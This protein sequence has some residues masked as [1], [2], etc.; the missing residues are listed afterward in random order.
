MALKTLPSSTKLKAL[1][2]E[3]V[4][5]LSG[6]P[7]ICLIAAGIFN[8]VAGLFAMCCPSL[9]STTLG[10]PEVNLILLRYIGLVAALFGTAYLVSSTDI[11]RY[12]PLI[13]VGLATKVIAPFGYLIATFS[14]E[15]THAMCWAVL[16][17]HVV[18]ILPFSI[19]VFKAINQSWRKDN[20]IGLEIPENTLS[21]Y[22]KVYKASKDKSLL[23]IFLRHFGCAFCQEAL[24]KVS[25][26]YKKLKKQDVTPVLVHMGE[27]EDF[28]QFIE[29]KGL[30]DCLEIEDKNQI[31]YSI[32]SIPRA[33]LR[34]AF[35]KGLIK[36]G[37]KV[38]RETGTGIGKLKGDGFQ[39]GGA[40]LVNNR[41]VTRVRSNQN[42][43]NDFSFSEFASGRDSSPEATTDGKLTLYYE[44]ACPVCKIEID[45]LKTLTSP[46]HVQYVD[47]GEEGLKLPKGKSKQDL[48]AE[49]HAQTESGE[50]VTGMEVFRKVYAHTPYSSIFNL[51]GLPVLKQLFDFSYKIFAKIRPYL[52]G[53]KADCQGSCPT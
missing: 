41:K 18:W 39:L 4:A 12:W 13:A 43:R 8:I 16:L 11:I 6:W 53:R 36:D 51:T 9:L 42:V 22:S 45:L 31:F 5:P 47:I 50:W 30:K 15:S 38:S 32:F 52:P 23:F 3:H 46:E 21:S 17:C 37:I 27:Q 2:A 26:E 48:L 24:I 40:A 25:E 19:I 10:L 28:Q 44:E 7:Q 29:E 35:P 33:N 34:K 1:G 49:I 20:G 14:S